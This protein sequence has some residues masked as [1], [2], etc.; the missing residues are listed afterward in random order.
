MGA[1]AIIVLLILIIW[2]FTWKNCPSGL[3]LTGF[4]LNLLMIFFALL[5]IFYTI[6]LLLTRDTCAN[7]EVAAIKA[8]SIKF[9]ATGMPTKVANYYLNGGKDGNGTSITLS[10][11]VSSISPD[12]DIDSMKGKINNTVADAVQSIT[13]QYTLRPRVSLA[14]AAHNSPPFAPRL[15]CIITTSEA[16]GLLNC[17]LIR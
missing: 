1:Y 7:V 17:C 14:A 10:Q 6:F 2:L 16:P 5:P 9:G 13:G 15:C 12:I 11:L 4:L 3:C 8:V